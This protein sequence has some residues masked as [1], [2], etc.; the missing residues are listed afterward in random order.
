[1][2]YSEIA[3]QVVYIDCG[4]CG[5]DNLWALYHVLSEAV[6]RWPHLSKEMQKSLK[7]IT[8][9]TKRYVISKMV[10]WIE[11]TSYIGMRCQSLWLPGRNTVLETGKVPFGKHILLVIREAKTHDRIVFNPWKS[12][13][14]AASL[15]LSTPCLRNHPKFSDI[16]VHSSSHI[17]MLKFTHH[18]QDKQC[19]LLQ[20]LVTHG[21]QDVKVVL[22]IGSGPKP[23]ASNPSFSTYCFW[24]FGPVCICKT[25]IITASL[26]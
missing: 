6:N 4:K 19:Q 5:E 21:V 1:M 23:L 9:G 24:D 16:E 14:K 26:S 13:Y 7:E 8:Q 22:H 17:V 2:S 25:G 20:I 3:T 11:Q 12:S 15:F 10:L 18:M